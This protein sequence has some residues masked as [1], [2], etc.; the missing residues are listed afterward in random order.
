MTDPPSP[1]RG[2]DTPGSNLPLVNSTLGPRRLTAVFSSRSEVARKAGQL[3]RLLRVLSH[4]P[5][6]IV[7]AVSGRDAVRRLRTQDVAKPGESEVLD[8][9]YVEVSGNV[10]WSSGSYRVTSVGG[11][12]V[13]AG[14]FMASWRKTN[15]K[16]L[17]V[18]EI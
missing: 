10:G 12:E 17:N 16:W 15:G 3:A 1:L 14:S 5:L 8:E 9:K 7:D 6:L 11:V 18:Q 4:P 2:C 13:A